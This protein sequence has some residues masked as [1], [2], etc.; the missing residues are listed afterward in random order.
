MKFQIGYDSNGNKILKIKV[1]NGRGFSIQTLGNL[2][3]T[4][5]MAT[6]ELDLETVEKEVREWVELFGTSRQKHVLEHN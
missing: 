3:A 5:R 6:G 4:H 2:T 1:T